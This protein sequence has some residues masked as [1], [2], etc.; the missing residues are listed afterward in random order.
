M[1]NPEKVLPTQESIEYRR[2]KQHIRARVEDK[3]VK[4]WIGQTKLQTQ[5][6]FIADRTIYSIGELTI[7]E[8]CKLEKWV[9]NK[10]I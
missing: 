6:M 9:I 10:S 8:L 2:R 5:A 7:T 1:I 4:A 3:A